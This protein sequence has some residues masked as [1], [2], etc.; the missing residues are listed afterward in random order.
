MLWVLAKYFKDMFHFTDVNKDISSNLKANSCF[1][2]LII[3]TYKEAFNKVLYNN[4]KCYKD[5]TPE[6]LCEILNIENKEQDLGLSI[7][8]S[9][10]F[11]EKFHLGLIVVNIYDEVIYKYIPEKFNK[12]I[13]PRTLYMLVYNNH[14]FRLDSN[15]NS[16]TKKLNSKEVIEHEKETYD[17]LKNSLSSRFYF[18]N[19]D[20][21]AKKI[22]IDNLDDVV[23]YVEGNDK[24]ENINFITNTD[25][26]DMLFQMIDNKYTPYVNFDSGI[27]SRLCF[28]IKAEEDDEK[29]IFYSIQHGDSSLIYDEIMTIEQSQIKNYDTADR[30]IYEW[31]LNK[32]NISQ[33]NEYIK[34]IENTYQMAPLS[35]YFDYCSVDDTYNTVDINKS[36][37]SNLIDIQRF[38]VFSAFDI[39]LKYDNHIIEDYTQYIIHCHDTNNETSIL[40]RKTFSR[41]YGYKLN[42]ISDF[43]YS[44]LFYR[45][46]SR[47]NTSHSKKH[48]DNLYRENIC[49][50]NVEDVEKKK[51][52]VNKNLGLLKKKYNSASITKIYKTMSEAQYYQ[53][54][55]G[56]YIHN[57]SDC[58][59]EEVDLTEEDRFI[60]CK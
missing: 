54:K 4:E 58:K 48:I 20:K 50:D 39:F 38:P 17:N 59:F 57:V 11:F 40:F 8:T 15:E 52:I 6:R 3:A 36:Y 44:I 25:L 35:G 60:Y 28:K 51:F 23:E 53:I 5:L 27:L 49:N 14:C 45:R 29:A 47:L 34:Q 55:Y 2:N 30:K 13:Y 16:F 33:R 26:A 22:Y 1:F 19:F 46:P 9:M 41:C 42:R 7:R 43:N 10:K 32:N 37:T 12:N 56:G 31:L 18:R 21:E 24:K